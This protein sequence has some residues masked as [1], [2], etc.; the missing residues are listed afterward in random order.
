MFRT[1]EDKIYRTGS[2]AE[3]QY[4]QTYTRSNLNSLSFIVCIITRI[5]TVSL[6]GIQ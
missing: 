5:E 3:S 6:P 2:L 4:M 1:S